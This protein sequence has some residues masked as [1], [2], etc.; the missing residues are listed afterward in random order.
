MT[1]ESFVVRPPMRAPSKSFFAGGAY[2]TSAFR[3]VV[4][5]LLAGIQ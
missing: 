5:F 1:A 3:K 4:G 2:V